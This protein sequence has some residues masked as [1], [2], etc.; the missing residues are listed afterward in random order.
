MG[1]CVLIVVVWEPTSLEGCWRVI[2]AMLVYLYCI[3]TTVF[4]GQ[5]TRTLSHFCNLDVLPK[6]WR[7][8]Q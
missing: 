1:S 7:Y 3:E 6:A 4:F 5:P 8:V 2:Y